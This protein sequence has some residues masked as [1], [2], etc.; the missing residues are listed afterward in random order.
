[1]NDYYL[2]KS[3]KPTKKYMVTHLNSDTGKLN[4]IHF[5]AN[6]MSDYTLHKDKDIKERYIKR[7]QV[8]ENFKDIKTAGAWA[9]GILWNK[10]SIESSI[11]DMEKRFKIKI[12]YVK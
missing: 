8:N 3:N 11:K 12:H 6:K 2:E 10:E 1:M 7:H 4:T 5:G 9:L